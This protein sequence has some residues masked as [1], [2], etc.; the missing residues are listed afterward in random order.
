MNG[1]KIG[2]IALS[3]MAICSSSARGQANE[4]ASD[5]IEVFDKYCFTPSADRT[6]AMN[7]APDD[8][9]NGKVIPPK[10]VEA[11]LGAP[12][13]AA[14]YVRATHKTLLKLQ[15]T[16]NNICSVEV[17]KAETAELVKAMSAFLEA[18]AKSDGIKFHVHDDNA[19]D[20]GGLHQHR[21]FYMVYQPKAGTTGFLAVNTL[22]GGQLDEHRGQFSFILTSDPY[23]EGK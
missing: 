11:D 15:F 12:G 18:K 4:T 23:T 6:V 16:P 13:G 2:A 17:P 1:L 22:D 20:E 21:I 9:V 5:V 8:G 7:T 10:Q 19:S 3:L 14:W